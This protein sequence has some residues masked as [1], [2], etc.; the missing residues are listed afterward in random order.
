[1][2]LQ[3]GH[4]LSSVETRYCRRSRCSGRTASMGPRSLKRGNELKRLCQELQEKRFNGATLSQ[5]WKQLASN[6]KIAADFGLQWGHA[7]SSVETGWTG[8]SWMCVFGFN[9]ATLSQAGKP[10]GSGAAG[11]LSKRFNGATL[12]Q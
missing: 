1:M 11:S 7:L 12:S 9:G 8:S 2:R 3:W 6:E 5:A 4:A 10:S